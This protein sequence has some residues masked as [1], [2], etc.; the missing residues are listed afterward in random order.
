MGLS[1]AYTLP[2]VKRLF[3][4]NVFGV[5]SV[6]KAVLPVMRQQRS[7]LVVHVSSELGRMTMPFSGIYSATKY[8]L[9]ALA[10]AWRY[11][12]SMVGIDSVLVEPGAFPTTDFTQH[13]SAYQAEKT[14]LVEAYGEFAVNLLPMMIKIFEQMKQSG[15]APSPF[16]TSIPVRRGKSGKRSIIKRK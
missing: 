3:E 11:E 4:A 16:T 13:M 15:H 10:E 9:E 7:G 5:F 14:D 12:L 8:A 2:V 6:T 1:E